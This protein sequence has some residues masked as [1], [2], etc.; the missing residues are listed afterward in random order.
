M[1]RG[2]ASLLREAVLELL[3]NACRYGTT[4]TTISASVVAAAD[5]VTLIFRSAGKPFSLPSQE[6]NENEAMGLSIVQ[7]VAISHRGHVSVLQDG[8]Y[9]QISLRLPLLRQNA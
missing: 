7:W 9:N 8:Q 1:I 3:E 5:S 6:R 2:N 4:G